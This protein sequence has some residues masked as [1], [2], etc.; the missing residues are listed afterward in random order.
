[1]SRFSYDQSAYLPERL[2]VLD[3]ETVAPAF[4]DGG[5]PPWP[6]HTPVVAA[7]LLASRERYDQW[8]FE[9]ETITFE[10]PASAVERVSNLIEGRTLVT[11]NG[12]GF[13]ILCLAM[14]AM[15]HRRF[16][17]RGIAEAWRAPRFSNVHHDLI[18]LIGNYGG[19]RACSLQ[20]LCEQ[21]GIP[22]KLGADGSEVGQMMARG[23]LKSV[24]TYCLEDVVGT[25]AAY[26]CVQ[27]LR[28]ASPTYAGS[29]ISQLGRWVREEKIGHLEPF[30]RLPGAGEFD[31][32]S[33]VGMIQAAIDSM[34]HRLDM[35]WITGTPGDTGA[36]AKKNSDYPA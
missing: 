29:L 21:L 9:A 19:G 27:A 34:D 12:K 15:K 7:V 22:V 5:F 4:P 26:A 32:Q 10:D 20:M 13:D 30:Q 6:L 2:A 3:I 17:L 25:C 36:L 1:M 16:A 28:A 24:G 35:T 31:R 14:T 8:K 33:I 18:D 23:D 11:M